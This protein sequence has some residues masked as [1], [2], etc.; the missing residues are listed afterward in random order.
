MIDQHSSLSEK[1]LK[2]GFW[3]YLFSFIIAPIWYII[4]IIVS[5]ELSVSEVWIIYWIISLIMLIS[6]FNDF[7]M[8]ESLNHFIPKFVSQ[9]RYDKVKTILFFAF[10]SQIITWII[11]W[12]FFFQFK[13]KQR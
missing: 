1:F 11:I 13:I 10:S 4:K 3:L 12:L 8:T 9:K 2:K 6:A 7:W 5:T